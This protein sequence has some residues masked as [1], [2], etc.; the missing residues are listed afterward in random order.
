MGIEPHRRDAAEDFR[1]AR[2]M[3]DAI[4]LAVR[5]TDGEH[6]SGVFAD[7]LDSSL[8]ILGV[9]AGIVLRADTRSRRW[10]VAER[11]C[12]PS[13]RESI[14]S[15]DPSDAA[16]NASRLGRPGAWTGSRFDTALGSAG[17]S[18]WSA[19]ALHSSVPG[20]AD[21]VEGSAW[22][23]AFG[24]VT[25]AI[26][27]V[28]ASPPATIA[29][30]LG[31]VIEACRT[32]LGRV[33]DRRA[34][35][36][37]AMLVSESNHGVLARVRRSPGW[38]VSV[39]GRDAAS[40]RA[41]GSALGIAPGADRDPLWVR[42]ED[43]GVE[44]WND[45]GSVVVHPLRLRSSE[46]SRVEVRSTLAALSVGPGGPL[47]YLALVQT[48][49]RERGSADGTGREAGLSVG[50]VRVDR[51][52]RVVW[53]NPEASSR[54]GLDRGPDRGA[55]TLRD[56]VHSEDANSILS[57]DHSAWS[58]ARV[59]WDGDW[60][61][62]GVV[63][64]RGARDG[65]VTLVLVP[66]GD[67]DLWATERAS[68]GLAAAQSGAGVGVLGLDE[69]IVS[70]NP[71]LARML[72]RTPESLRGTDWRAI[73]TP[74]DIARCETLV[75]ELAAGRRPTV[76]VQKNYL[77][78]DG[79]RLLGLACLSRIEDEEG[80][81][82]GVSAII[83]DLSSRREIQERLG[84]LITPS[85]PGKPGAD[86]TPTKAGGLVAS[87]GTPVIR[88]LVIDD[89]PLVRETIVA[90]LAE[91]GFE[92]EGAL[93]GT[94][95]R[96][97]LRESRAEGHPFD[98]LVCDATLLHEDGFELAAGLAR[99]NPGI[100]VV[101]ISGDAKRP[102]GC[103]FLLV[104]KPFRHEDLTAALQSAIPIRETSAS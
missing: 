1:D 51:L 46:S 90:M 77:R 6:E 37:A 80:Q 99:E 21:V 10:I 4:R 86:T 22:I 94:A 14:E 64:V 38:D 23:V 75:S 84:T 5:S 7:I 36:A 25:E 104:T 31:V 34:L 29:V 50:I 16:L 27:G 67:G 57:G 19:S 100:R 30:E 9:D 96:A 65:T 87:D 63:R 24:R 20:A 68:W 56:L 78:A 52:G 79:T 48:G 18:G 61:R 83:H 54:M 74:E 98:A 62:V 82:R 55:F 12:P 91:E 59:R 2:R 72:G 35:A 73:T 44:S 70:V 66:G 26:P 28:A 103:L 32:R 3:M 15:G 47:A 60:R 92:A 81:L 42:A 76:L 17:L 33:A 88:V 58:S 89:Q 93:G 43:P 101:M 85:E 102:A 97:M 8:G 13:V 11:G 45:T 49:V 53:S 69:R 71:S 39:V 41:F 40:S 95:A